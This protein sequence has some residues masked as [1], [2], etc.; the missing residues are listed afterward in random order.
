MTNK[1]SR[2]TCGNNSTNGFVVD[3]YEHAIDG[4]DAEIRSE[5]EE[6][7]ADEWNAS[8]LIKRWMLSRKIE[9]EIR[10]LVTERSKHISPDAHF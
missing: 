8:G 3:G 1:P 10:T 7:Y 4:I 6:K 9:K 5:V 2:A